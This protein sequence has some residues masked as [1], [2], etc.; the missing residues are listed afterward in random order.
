MDSAPRM[1]DFEDHLLPATRVLRQ[2]G[3]YPARKHR[4]TILIAVITSLLL[5]ATIFFAYN[6]SLAQPVAPSLRFTVPERN[7]FVLTLLTQLTIFSL[8]EL[9]S[10]VL[11]LVRW[12]FS[13]GASGV[14]AFT[15][16]ALSRATNILGVLYLVL[17][18]ARSSRGFGT[19][20]HR[21]W[22]C[23][24]CSSPGNQLTAKAVIRTRATHP[25]CF[26]SL[27]YLLR[28]GL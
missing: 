18:T 25:W 8:A 2:A 10:T 1:V 13:C 19:T 11:D 17:G 9:T 5:G 28:F 20:G 12:A 24:R 27:R 21:L 6:C 7:V 22:G 14:S 4:I 23:Q 15:F 26:T 3:E 16:L